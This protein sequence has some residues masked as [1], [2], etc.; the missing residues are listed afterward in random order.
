M[1]NLYL[2]FFACLLGYLTYYYLSN[3]R[4]K[5]HKDIY[6]AFYQIFPQKQPHF[7]IEQA[8]QAGQLSPLSLANQW[9]YIGISIVLCSIIQTLTKDLTLTCFYMS[10]LV[11]LF[12]IG[13]LDWHYQL[14]EPALCQLLLLILSGAS[15]FRLISNSLED[16]VESAVISF[17]IFYLV[18]HISKLCYKK[19]VF[20]QGDYWL[21]SALSAG[22][23]W[24]DIPLM[25][26]LA[27]LLALF[28]ALIYNR[29]LAHTKISLV[30]FAPFLCTANLVTLF[31]K[32]LI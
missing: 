10:Y 11:L 21:I 1:S 31:I 5:L 2:V 28:Y 9:I 18:Y 4:T 3:F 19:E 6:Y 8:D 7:T 26:S 17:V 15:Y 12:I 25:I 20:G 29:L 22:L 23:S 14:I 13:K 32:M 16:V 30:P 24:R 27:C